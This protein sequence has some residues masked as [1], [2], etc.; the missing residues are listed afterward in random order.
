MTAHPHQLYAVE[1]TEA[2]QVR[3]VGFSCGEE[4]WSKHVTEWITGS[5]VLD[6]MEKYGTRV[7][8]FETKQGEIVGFGSVGATV[9][10]WPPPDGV[11][12][13]IILIPML[14][15]DVRFHGQPPDPNW[16]YSRQ[17]MGHLIAEG[18]KLGREWPEDKGEKPTW[19]VL[20]VRR[21]N[22]RAI[23]CYESCGFE[24]IPNVIR[25]NDHVVMKLW[26]GEAGE[27]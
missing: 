16:R 5:D 21:D 14:G 8:L 27:S 26:I 23:R 10:R 24:L 7:W 25:R 18:T 3:L 15:I 19:L 13:N 2:D 11:R 22:A 6:S 1:F 12:T 4:I 20:M 9:W 17:I